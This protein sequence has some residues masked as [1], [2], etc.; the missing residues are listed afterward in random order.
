MRSLVTLYPQPRREREIITV[1]QC[2]LPFHVS[3]SIWDLNPVHYTAHIQREYSFFNWGSSQ[4]ALGRLRT[5]ALD[6][7]KNGWS[8]RT[9]F[10]VK[11]V[12]FIIY[13]Y[14]L[15]AS[16]WVCLWVPVEAWRGCWIAWNWSYRLLWVTQSR[17]WELL[18]FFAT[19]TGSS[20]HWDSSPVPCSNLLLLLHIFYISWGNTYDSIVKYMERLSHRSL[21]RKIR[22]T[23]IAF[24]F[25]LFKIYLFIV[26]QYVSLWVYVHHICTV[27]R[28][29]R[30]GYY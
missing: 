5:T 3:Y 17:Y 29:A 12:Y 24:R 20:N 26:C 1:V 9:I 15:F 23:I 22:G 27:L 18:L 13:L 21:G 14:V 16:V 25:Y 11:N 2:P 10:F 30:R 4:H 6:H 28:E 19:A 7:K 8:L